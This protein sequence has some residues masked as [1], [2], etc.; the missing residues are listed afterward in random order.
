MLP[1]PNAATAVSSANTTPSHLIRSPRSSTYIGPPAIAPDGVVTRYFTASSA[2]P[3]FVAI[4]NTPV[5]HIHSTAPGPPAAT[6]VATPT[7]LPVP[8]VAASAVASAPNWLTSPVPSAERP[9]EIRIPL[10][11]NRWMNRSRTVR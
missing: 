8:I 7:M 1:M 6:A 10:P 2:S 5:S 11:M 9:S 3:Y 4:P